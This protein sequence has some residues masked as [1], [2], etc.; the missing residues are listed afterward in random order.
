MIRNELVEAVFFENVLKARHR[1]ETRA[2]RCQIVRNRAEIGGRVR[3]VLKKIKRSEGVKGPVLENLI[4]PLRVFLR[5]R[6][7]LFARLYN[8]LVK[9]LHP[10]GP[11]RIFRENREK[12]A[13]PAARLQNLLP[14]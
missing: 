11:D 12:L 3:L 2:L 13:L 6:E 14:L 5:D 4:L 9:M 7:S 8:E 1:H 10:V